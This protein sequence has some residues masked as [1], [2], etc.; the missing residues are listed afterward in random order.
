MKFIKRNW[1][2]LV[3]TIIGLTAVLIPAYYS[4]LGNK[5][6]L[7]YEIVSSYPLIAVD[8][9]EASKLQVLFE[10]K[11][12]I[13]PYINEISISN[14]GNKPILPEYYE[15]DI[16]LSFGEKVEIAEAKITKR[17]PENIS[18]VLIQ[19]GRDLYISSALFN[20][21]DSIILRVL[22]ANEKP[23]IKINARVAGIK[24][25]LPVDTENKKGKYIAV[26]LL[27]ILGLIFSIGY[28]LSTNLYLERNKEFK[29]VSSP[30]KSLLYFAICNAVSI[31]AV[32][33]TLSEFLEFSPF[34]FLAIYIALIFAGE[35]LMRVFKLQ[36]QKET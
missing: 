17:N 27:I 9:G 30:S 21:S 4:V 1:K 24:N 20:P 33:I 3:T 34:N 23:E 15:G 5:L 7:R 12:I 11:E 8:G 16:K 6:D 10:E 14:L 28:A 2:W 31:C 22:T 32:I 18:S 25:I 13:K 26:S 35:I 29:T 19:S 36:K